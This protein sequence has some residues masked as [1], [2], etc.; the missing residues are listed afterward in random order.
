MNAEKLE[1]GIHYNGQSYSVWHYKE[2]P[3]G[4]RPAKLQDLI[5]RKLVLYQVRIGPHKGEY[6]TDIVRPKT[7]DI[8]RDMINSGHPI[9]VKS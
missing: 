2:V 3:E 1:F 7:I 9:F 8:L 5:W 4:M 6:Y